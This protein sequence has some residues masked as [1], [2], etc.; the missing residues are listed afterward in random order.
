[1]VWLSNAIRKPD[2]KV[3]FSNGFGQNGSQ[4]IRFLNTFIIKKRPVFEC[5]QYLN[6]WFLDP[7]CKYIF[8]P[9]IFH[10]PP[11]PPFLGLN[12]GSTIPKANALQSELSRLEAIYKLCIFQFLFDVITKFWKKID[13]VWDQ[14]F[15]HGINWCLLKAQ[16]SVNSLKYNYDIC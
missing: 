13:F 1:M 9:G 12:R 8:Y 3:Q 7:H 2:Q 11:P 6:V 4:N 15:E 14:R 10:P 5:F 16:F